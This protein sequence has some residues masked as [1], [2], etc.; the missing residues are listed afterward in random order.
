MLLPR[1]GVEL[2][3]MI[4][5]LTEYKLNATDQITINENKSQIGFKTKRRAGA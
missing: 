2:T 3:F 4:T 5:Y 1:T